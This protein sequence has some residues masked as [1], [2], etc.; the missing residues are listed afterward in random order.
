MNNK[1]GESIMETKELGNKEL[2]KQT[3]STTQEIPSH[4]LYPEKDLP[5]FLKEQAD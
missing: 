2:Q 3:A 5:L 1:Q 4:E